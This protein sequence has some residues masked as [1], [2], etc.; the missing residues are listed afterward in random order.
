MVDLLHRLA[1]EVWNKSMETQIVTYT[2]QIVFLETIDTRADSTA[3][4]STGFTYVS[5][6]YGD[7]VGT[8]YLS[9]NADNRV[10]LVTADG[11]TRIL[12]GTGVASNSTTAGNGDDS[13]NNK[14]RMLSTASTA[15]P[16]SSPSYYTNTLSQIKTVA[17]TGTLGVAPTPYP[18]TAS[19]LS[20]PVG[21]W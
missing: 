2:L 1:L 11:M 5:G 7:T 8:L 12:A 19:L 10:R 9:C 18:A 3:A 17:G 21:V 15:A 4:T 20:N 13:N 14:V 16:T 6:L